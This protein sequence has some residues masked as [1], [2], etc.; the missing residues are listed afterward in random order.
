MPRLTAGHTE[1]SHAKAQRTQR[2]FLHKGLKNSTFLNIQVLLT[3]FAALRDIIPLAKTP[4][5][6]RVF[7]LKSQKTLLL[8]IFES[9]SRPL[10]LCVTL[11]LS[12]RR[13]ERK[14]IACIKAPKIPAY[15]LF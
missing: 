1:S 2:V 5:T 3:S 11:S 4:R 12:P 15:S 13:K 10:R 9:S 6:Q 7:L 8:I 14:D